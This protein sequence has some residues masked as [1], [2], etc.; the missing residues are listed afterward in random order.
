[1]YA[2]KV[3]GYG[4]NSF[5]IIHTNATT[6]TNDVMITIPF[7]IYNLI[8]GAD[9]RTSVPNW[10]NGLWQY[11]AFTPI[12]AAASVKGLGSMS[13]DVFAQ[14]K[15]NMYAV[16]YVDNATGITVSVTFIFGSFNQ[17]QS[18]AWEFPWGNGESS[19]FTITGL[20]KS[21]TPKNP[22]TIRLLNGTT[23]VARTTIA[24]ATGAGQITQ[25][26]T[27]TNVPAGTYNLEVT[28]TGHTK[29]TVTGV[30]VNSGN[31]IDLT[32]AT[33][34]AYSVITLV[35]GDINNSGGVDITDLNA[36]VGGYGKSA[37]AYT[38]ASNPDIDGSGG[39]DIE[40]L[41]IVVGSYGKTNVVVSY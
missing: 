16:A 17:A 8:A 28:K 36:A 10:L 38:A 32:A 19:G 2:G 6:P 20:V 24:A 27:L 30:T 11:I 12:P 25:I 5:I 21:Y 4:T 31:N 26:F 34:K 41:N 15:N 14:N 13:N 35:G 7:G 9:L 3:M 18:G 23:E 1:M 39:I 33:G 22:T 40:D 37:S 29:Y